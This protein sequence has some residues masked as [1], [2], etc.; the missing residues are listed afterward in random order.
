MAYQQKRGN[1]IM[2]R[3]KK[4]R[5]GVATGGDKI[6]SKEHSKAGRHRAYQWRLSEKPISVIK[7][8]TRMFDVAHWR[9]SDM[10]SLARRDVARQC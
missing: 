6:E 3:E 8:H 1:S 5:H 2:A 4:Q 7:W 10:A 9:D